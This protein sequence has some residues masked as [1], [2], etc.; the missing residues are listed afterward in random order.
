EEWT[1]EVK[2]WRDTYGMTAVYSD[3]M[4]QDDWLS[5]YEAMRRLRGEVFP[6]GD[7]V[8]HDSY[9]QSGIPAAAF[10]PFLYSYATA[11]YMGETAQAS[12]AMTQAQPLALSSICLLRCVVLPSITVISRSTE[13]KCQSWTAVPQNLSM[14]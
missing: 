3:G 14:P 13:K 7:I 9:P 2:R 10:R 6:D 4:A 5:A 8:I 11:T 1:N 12:G